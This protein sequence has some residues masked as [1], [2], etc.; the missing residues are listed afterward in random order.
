[1][2]G[3]TTSS[4]LASALTGGNLFTGSMVGDNGDTSPAYIT[5]QK[6]VGFAA[7]RKIGFRL[8]EPLNIPATED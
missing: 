4:T 7:G 6:E 2:G 3:G 5:E 8:I 1:M